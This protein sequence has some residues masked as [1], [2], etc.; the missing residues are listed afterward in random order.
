MNMHLTMRTRLT[1]W[2]ALILAVILGVFITGVYHHV[3]ESLYEQIDLR[4]KDSLLVLTNITKSSANLDNSHDEFQE[5]EQL[6]STLAFQVIEAGAKSVDDFPLYISEKWREEHLDDAFQQQQSFEVWKFTTKRAHIFHLKE[7]SL[8]ANNVTLRLIV[9]EPADDLH[10]TLNGLY[11]S[12]LT[13]YPA[14]LLLSLFLGYF[15]AGRALSPIKQ[16]ANR[17]KTISADNLTERIFIADSRDELGQLATVLN[18]SFARLDASFTQL[19]RFTQNAAHELRTPLAV[20]RSI[21]EV[22]IQKNR[23]VS[24]YHEV[25]GSMLE[26]VDRLSR[27]VDDL[28]ILTRAD[29]GTS[30][31]QLRHEDITLLCQEVVE[32]LRILAYDKQQTLIIESPDKIHAFVDR[33]K[34][35]LALINIVANALQYTP[36]GGRVC[37]FIYEN[38]ASQN[39]YIEIDDN[40]SGIEA[41]HRT[42]LFER[43]YRIDS[44]RSLHPNGTG[45]GLAIA[46]WAVET[47]GGQIDLVEKSSSGS[48]FKIALPSKKL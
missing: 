23:D 2:Q 27:L 33:E 24:S 14:A 4:L 48:L 20:L 32:C 6:R 34:L 44:T 18:H 46:R 41:Q 26:E 22:G 1:L 5:V 25:V 37:V 43:F 31:I 35:R 15:F 16:L 19:R 28:L 47:C 12:L 38:S 36:S 29:S 42:L 21:G 11:F 30:A 10:R 40:G 13:G 17:A 45:L 8:K 39:A 3:R 7:A 9:A